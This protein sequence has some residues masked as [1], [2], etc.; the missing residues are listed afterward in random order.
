MKTSLL[1]ACACVLLSACSKV[2]KQ[3]DSFEKTAG[4]M[5]KTTTKVAYTADDIKEIAD[6]IFP[7]IRTGDTVRVRNEEWDILTNKE[8]GLGEKLVAAGIFFQALEYQF[9]TSN[10]YD[11]KA[12]LELMYR[13]AADEFQGRM[14]D[15]YRKID[16]ED[17]SPTKL[18]KRQSDEMAF[19]A[20]A[21]TMDRSHH[22]QAELSKKHPNLKFVTFLDIIQNALLKEK[23]GGKVEK[24]EA[25]LL[26]GINKEII[27]ELYKARVDILAALALRDLVDQRNMS[28]SHYSKAAVFKLTGGRLGSIDVPETF[29]TANIYTKQSAENYLLA[30][31][32]A[33]TFLDKIEIPH[34]LEK[35]VRSA[36]KKVDLNDDD[37]STT[38][39]EKAELNNLIQQ[40][41]K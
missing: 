17:M 20:L 1:I 36:L 34:T 40:L 9:W 35:T 3:I 30:A 25:I 10:N 32:K 14:Y 26:S 16:I 41:V 19:Y 18:G 13:D 5:D 12:V 27:V 28:I 15:L 7:Q 29:E 37:M 4:N 11:N 21:M 23:K 22:F 38:D 39:E 6:A 24:H 8:K 31:L 2:E 33:K